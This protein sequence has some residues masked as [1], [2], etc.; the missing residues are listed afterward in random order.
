MFK[1]ILFATDFSPHANT[2]GQMAMKLAQADGKRLW[3]L[4]VLEPVDEPLK[5]TDEPPEI[6]RRKWEKMLQKEEQQ[7]E[8][9]RD[10]ALATA[11]AEMEAAG[12]NVTRMVK[13]GDP[14]RQIVAAA[15][16]ID[17]DLIV[18]GSHSRR[19]LWDV[20]LGSVA[21]KV[22]EH[23]PCP[24]LIVSHK[25]PHPDIASERILF[26][27]DFSPHAEMAQNVAFTLAKEAGQ[28][29]LWVMAVI[30]PGDELPMLP[31]FVVE[32]DDGAV[33]ELAA[34]LRDEVEKKV[35]AKLA[36]IE[37]AAQEYGITAETLIKHGYPDKEIVKTAIDME[38]DMIVLGSHSR[39]GILDVLL[40]NTAESVSRKAPCPV[41]VVSHK[42]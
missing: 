20:V 4:T 41:L 28:Q 13:E 42:N 16:E 24:V 11:V 26:A 36:E 25:P 29:H 8:R 3:V 23:A 32:V 35:R 9:N 14:D 31:G 39:R 21:A 33:Y 19:T 15:E 17:A 30:K 40:G 10:A 34:E 6:P 27:T 12:I 18:I 7:L 1:R 2:A 5:M 37:S 38:A 22:A